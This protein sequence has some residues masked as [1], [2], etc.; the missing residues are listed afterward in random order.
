[1]SNKRLLSCQYFSDK[2]ILNSLCHIYL[3]LAL[4]FPEWGYGTWCVP[5]IVQTCIHTHT[6]IVSMA[7]LFT[8]LDIWALNG[9]LAGWECLY[10]CCMYGIFCATISRLAAAKL[11][12]NNLSKAINGLGSL[13]LDVSE[14]IISNKESRSASNAVLPPILKI[15][16]YFV[17]ILA[18]PQ[19]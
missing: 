4:L 19:T 14:L 8:G 17:D 10:F 1:M 5:D 2:L 11:C 3:H 13:Y 6:H 7:L 18:V 12:I 15:V 16:Y 9:W